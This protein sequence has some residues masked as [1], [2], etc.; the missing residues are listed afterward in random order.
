MAAAGRMLTKESGSF[1]ELAVS[2]AANPADDESASEKEP[3]ERECRELG[4]TCC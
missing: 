4:G 3:S 1:G 2:C